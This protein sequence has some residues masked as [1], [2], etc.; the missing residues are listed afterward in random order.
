MR[1]LCLNLAAD[2]SSLKFNI[3]ALRPDIISAAAVSVLRSTTL[4][5][6]GNFG[7]DVTT[8]I[9]TVVAMVVQCHSHI[10]AVASASA[11]TFATIRVTAFGLIA[12]RSLLVR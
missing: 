1:S 11:D 4:T 3:A 12:C 9:V 6:M 10:P 7:D 5:V 8:T 2:R